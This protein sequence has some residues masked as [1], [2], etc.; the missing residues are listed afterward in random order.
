M[1]DFIEFV[2]T[3]RFIPRK[4]FLSK[5]PNEVLLNDCTDLVHYEG[6]HYIQVLKDGKFYL[7]ELNQSKELDEVEL[8]LY[9]RKIGNDHQD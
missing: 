4:D 2:D 7:D 3:G 8:V 1:K 9:S 6:G 5:R